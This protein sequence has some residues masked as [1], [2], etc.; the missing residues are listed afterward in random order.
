MKSLVR[1]LFV[2]YD[3]RVQT[4]VFDYLIHYLMKNELLYP[5][6]VSI[7]LLFDY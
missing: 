6:I 3:Q 2:W 1:K 7:H 4:Y 5:K